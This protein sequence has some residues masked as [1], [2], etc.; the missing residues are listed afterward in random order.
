LTFPEAVLREA[1][2]TVEAV[3]AGQASRQALC[4]AAKVM[5]RHAASHLAEARKVPPSRKAL[6][7]L[8]PAVLA[9]GHLKVLES[10]GWDPFDIRVSRPRPQPLRLAWANIRGRI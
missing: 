1:G 9:S 8:L 6:P 10:A 2:N 4:V 3:L 7:A 5:A